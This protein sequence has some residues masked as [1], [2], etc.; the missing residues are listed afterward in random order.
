MGKNIWRPV[1]SVDRP[2]EMS[3]AEA[4]LYN[5]LHDTRDKAK[6]QE[7]IGALTK[8]DHILSEGE[9]KILSFCQEILKDEK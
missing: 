4:L 1:E 6:A 8:S 2:L 5:E 3:E 9:E 7:T